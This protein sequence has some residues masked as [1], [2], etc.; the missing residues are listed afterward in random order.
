LVVK[1]L[2]NN[3]TW[4]LPG[5][6]LHRNEQ[7]LDG[8]LREVREEVKLNFRKKDVRSLGSELYTERG[9]SFMCHYFVIE[10]PKILSPKLTIELVD[11][12]WA[13]KKELTS[14]RLGKDVITAL[15]LV[16]G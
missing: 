16:Q 14:L 3:N 2:I 7:A 11:S 6:G 15:R 13:V 5:G 4:T 12:M 10:I 1:T 9:V 8:V